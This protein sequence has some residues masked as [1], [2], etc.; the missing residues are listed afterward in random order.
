[1]RN[2]Y[3]LCFKCICWSLFIFYNSTDTFAQNEKLADSTYFISYTD[4]IVVGVNADTQTDTYVF[5]DN[6][7]IDR[8]EISSINQNKLSVSIDYKFIGFSVGFA[9]S[10]LNDSNAE[11]L[12]GKSEYT[13]YKFHFF[14]GKF[15]QSIQYRRIKGYY[16]V[17]TGDIL[18]NWQ[19]G[20]DPYIQFPDLKITKYGMS[21]SYVFNKNFSYRS[22]V[23]YTERQVKSAGSFV[24]QLFYDYSRFTNIFM[25]EKS[26]EEQ[27]NFR[28][29]LGYYYNWVIYRKWSIASG[30]SPSWGI[31]FSNFVDTDENGENISEKNEYFTT[32]LDGGL[33]VG[34][35]GP[36][37][38]CGAKAI[39]N[40]NWYDEDSESHVE[41]NQI[42]SLLYVGFRFN[43]P[44]FIKRPVEDVENTM[45]KT[46]KNLGKDKSS[47]STS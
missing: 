13:D 19:E 21:T 22:L 44:R 36:H 31:R 35:N 45:Q 34:F 38:F 37:F 18:N 5:T 7:F 24:P 47:S 11:D 28:L 26:V 20:Q 27:F 4:K 42:Y 46:M 25:D 33:Q 3:T 39:F 30:L 23:G 40:V 1:M 17:N 6:T 14:F 8:M 2:F 12:K 9:P 43:A 15:V 16:L 10:F 29:A 41:N 32:A